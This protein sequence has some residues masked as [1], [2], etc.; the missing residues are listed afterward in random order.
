MPVGKVFPIEAKT[1]K[2]MLR[3]TWISKTLCMPCMCFSLHS[4]IKPSKS[5]ETRE[6][7]MGIGN[8]SMI[9]KEQWKGWVCPRDY[10]VEKEYH[11]YVV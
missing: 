5:M 6:A 4:P 11:P 9:T 10:V 2:E 3:V 7:R 8:L 1:G